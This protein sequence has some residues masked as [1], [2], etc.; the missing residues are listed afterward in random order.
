MKSFYSMAKAAA[1]PTAA[2]TTSLDQLKRL[3]APVKAVADGADVVKVPLEVGTGAAEAAVLIWIWPSEIWLAPA[4]VV[5]AWSWPSEICLTAAAV[6][7]GTWTWPSEICLTA[8]AVLVA[9]WI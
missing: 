3:A 6:L 4:T 8:A 5:G 1:A 9:A 2:T 7:V